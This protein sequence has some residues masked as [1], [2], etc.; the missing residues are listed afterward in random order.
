MVG[1]RT[2]GNSYT[3]E[4]RSTK[5]ANIDNPGNQL[6]LLKARI[7]LEN[8]SNPTKVLPESKLKPSYKPQGGENTTRRKTESQ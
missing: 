4:E 8:L 7:Y 5:K 3:A 2:A 6:G 1:P